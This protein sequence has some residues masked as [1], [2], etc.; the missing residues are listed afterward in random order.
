MPVAVSTHLSA[1]SWGLAA[2]AEGLIVLV[3]VLR[4]SHYSY[5][6]ACNAESLARV[7]GPNGLVLIV[8]KWDSLPSRYFFFGLITPAG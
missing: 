3:V 4:H 5:V 7:D 1:N 8:Q 6:Q 2:N